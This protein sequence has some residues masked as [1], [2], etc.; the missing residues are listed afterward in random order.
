MMVHNPLPFKMRS[1]NEDAGKDMKPT[2]SRPVITSSGE[3]ELL[4]LQREVDIALSQHVKEQA[5]LRLIKKEIIAEIE[6]MRES[7]NS[8]NLGRKEK[9]ENESDKRVRFF[10]EQS[11]QLASNIPEAI[12]RPIEQHQ[13]NAS[14]RASKD[15]VPK[16]DEIRRD[17]RIMAKSV[18]KSEKE[19]EG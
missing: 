7:K 18:R 8:S 2:R 3:R 19:W 4:T 14:K 12:T 1:S 17:L 15:I 16:A 13:H 11:L 5:E 9:D 6:R 10:D